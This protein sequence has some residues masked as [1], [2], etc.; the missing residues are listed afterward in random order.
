MRV[1]PYF[2]PI[3]NTFND[4]LELKYLNQHFVNL[5]HT[6]GL[7]YNNNFFDYVIHQ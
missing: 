2:L 1:Q 7:K 5:Q 4:V 3:F 6:F